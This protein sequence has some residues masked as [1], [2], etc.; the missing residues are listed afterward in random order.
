M[1]W[2]HAYTITHSPLSQASF[3][4][5]LRGILSLVSSACT[6]AVHCCTAGRDGVTTRGIHQYRL[7]WMDQSMI[8]TGKAGITTNWRCSYQQRTKLTCRAGV[9]VRVKQDMSKHPNFGMSLQG[10]DYNSTSCF[11]IWETI[12]YNYYNTYVLCY[13][14]NIVGMPYI[15]RD[16]LYVT[17]TSDNSRC[18]KRSN[19]VFFQYYSPSHWMQS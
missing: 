5:L 15:E 13:V 19:G 17:L 2:T 6:G 8:A 4:Q 3:K 9:R 16:I 14:L 1:D 10:V 18:W 11:A 7:R 12:L